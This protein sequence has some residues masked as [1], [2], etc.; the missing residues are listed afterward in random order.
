MGVLYMQGVGKSYSSG[1]WGRKRLVLSDLSLEIRQGEV[2]GLLGHNGAG[3]TTT[4]RLV[5]GLL[6]PDTG[7]IT[8]HGKSNRAKESRSRIGYLGDEIGLYPQFSADEIMQLT[9]E[10]F[11]MEPRFLRKRKTHLL[12]TVGLSSHTDLKVKKYS[13]GMR[14]RLG[15]ALALLNEPDFLILDEPYSGLDPIGRRDVRQLLLNLKKEGATILLSSHI[16]PDVEAVCDRV[17]ILSGGRIQRCLA[18]K[19]IYAHKKASVEITVSGV[20][21]SIFDNN[22]SVDTL[23]DNGEAIVFRCEG[24]DIVKEVVTKVYAFD[25]TVLEVKPLKFNLEDYLLEALVEVDPA[26]DGTKTS[27]SP[28]EMTYA[29]SQ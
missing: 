26:R 20:D 29:H 1:F 3:K 15:I 10:L 21:R 22:P 19:D 16:V 27:A 2:F 14:Q 23:Y 13:K 6:R 7:R 11:R 25:G 18:L 24:A 12:E 8:L 4:M 9:G 17:G 5:L 28:E